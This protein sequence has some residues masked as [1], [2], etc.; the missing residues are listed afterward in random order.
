MD[1]LR[2]QRIGSSHVWFQKGVAI[3]DDI[4]AA[5]TNR[6]IMWDLTTGKEILT[7]KGGEMGF[8]ALDDQ[9][10]AWAQAG[11]WAKDEINVRRYRS[12]Y[13]FIIKEEE[14]EEEG[15]EEEEEEE[16]EE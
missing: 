10:V 15:E 16:E 11:H 7:Y 5:C 1:I 4:V 3:H 14:E 13:G 9:Y 2:P 6:L 8:V 12:P